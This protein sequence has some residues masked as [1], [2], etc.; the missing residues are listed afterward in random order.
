MNH[1][2]LAA[3]AELTL[4]TAAQ[5]LDQLRSAPAPVAVDLTETNEV[6]IA[7]LQLLVA[8]AAD[9]RFRFTPARPAPLVAACQSAGIDPHT[10]ALGD[11]DV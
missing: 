2:L 7:G 9:P 11:H 4:R 5:F 6:D 10:F 8:A 3:P 1:P